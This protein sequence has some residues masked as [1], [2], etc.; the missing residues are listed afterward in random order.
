[1]KSEG[2][3]K[4]KTK[5]NQNKINEII[6]LYS[7]NHSMGEIS[8]IVNI[9]VS[10]IWRVLKINNIPSKNQ[11]N[12]RDKLKKYHIN[13]NFFNKIDSPEK[14]YILGLLYADGN[15][16]KKIKQITLKLQVNDKP[17]LDRISLL[18]ETDKPLHFVKKSKTT[19]Q[20]QYVLKITNK[21]IYTDL[22]NH[23]IVPNKTF[24]TTFPKLEEQLIPH[25]IRG[26]F[27]G[28][29]C[30]YVGKQNRA[31]WSIIGSTNFINSVQNLIQEKLNIKSYIQHD[32]RCK[33]GIDI[34]RIRRLSDIKKISEWMWCN[35]TIHLERKY[36][37]YKI[38][39]EEKNDNIY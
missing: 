35:S 5:I 19:H 26:Y 14:A 17:V 16:N 21:V 20:D 30:F 1:M 28:D 11:F 37:K 4:M 12:Y 36:N 32:K 39:K 29:G 25:F 18:I 9:C 31:C 27:D 3:N 38:I 23:G 10:Q 24:I 6:D 8:K 33:A 7:K 22:V 2:E 34:L 13:E 15:A